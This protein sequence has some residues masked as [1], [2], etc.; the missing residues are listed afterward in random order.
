VDFFGQNQKVPSARL[1]V[2]DRFKKLPC[3]PL[4]I[5]EKNNKKK[6]EYGLK[7]EVHISTDLN[8]GVISI[9]D[10]DMFGVA[11]YLSVF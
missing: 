3:K 10:R 1:C 7:S 5:Q 9:G 2:E 8:F 11:V 6:Q 4:N